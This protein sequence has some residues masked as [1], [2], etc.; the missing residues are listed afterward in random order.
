M[1]AVEESPETPLPAGRMTRGIVRRRG[2]LWRPMWPWSPAVHEY[3][4]HL[5]SAGFTGAPLLP[6]VEGDREVLTYV[7]GEAAADPDWEPVTRTG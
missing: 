3:L 6:G 1:A 5:E 2:R 7:E 4:R